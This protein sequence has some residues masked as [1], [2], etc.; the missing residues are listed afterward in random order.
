MA[1]SFYYSDVH[2]ARTGLGEGKKGRGKPK[3]PEKQML[4]ENRIFTVPRKHRS[5]GTKK[6]G[7][8]ISATKGER[9]NIRG[10][11]VFN[12]AINKDGALQHVRERHVVEM[13]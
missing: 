11:K 1:R 8:A 2:V 9:K 6:K 5:T 7:R 12:Q 3:H 10:L 13:P 4:F